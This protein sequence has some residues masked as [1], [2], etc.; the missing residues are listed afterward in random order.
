MQLCRVESNQ[1]RGRQKKKK[2]NEARG[3]TRGG[4]RLALQKN[5]GN[6]GVSGGVES[7]HRKHGGSSFCEVMET[8]DARSCRMVDTGKNMFSTLGGSPEV[9]EFVLLNGVSRVKGGYLR[10]RESWTY[11]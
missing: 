2:K 1:K 5:L 10:L 8:S 3:D 6:A 11:S 4:G 9:T 7:T